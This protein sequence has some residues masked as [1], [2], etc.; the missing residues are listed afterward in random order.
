MILHRCSRPAGS[1]IVLTAL[2]AAGCGSPPPAHPAVGRTLGS[3][4]IAPVADSGAAAPRLAGKVTLLNVW[5]TWCPPCRAELPGLVRLA[6]RLADDP[7][8]QLV[9]I[10]SNPAAD[11]FPEVA[12]ETRAFLEQERIDLDAWACVDPVGRD[13]LFSTIGLEGFPT[14]ALVGPDARIR[15]VWVGYRPRDEVEIAAAVV[16]LLA[17]LPA[18]R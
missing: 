17:E 6:D 7:R 2:A 8:F 10:S 13:I 4:P 11:D 5:G 14:T 3:L 1:L 18:A 16:S 9:A 15:R 12:A